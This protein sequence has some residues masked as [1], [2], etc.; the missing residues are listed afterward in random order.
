MEFIVQI[1]RIAAMTT[2]K[3][4]GAIEDRLS[5]LLALEEDKFV[6]GFHQ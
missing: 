6:I 5:Q 4:F 2:L 1:L 3:Y